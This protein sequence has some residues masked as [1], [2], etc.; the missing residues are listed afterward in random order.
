V[1]LAGESRK[2]PPVPV[3]ITIGVFQNYGGTCSQPSVTYYMH[4]MHF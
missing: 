1:A 4:I 2:F 3:S